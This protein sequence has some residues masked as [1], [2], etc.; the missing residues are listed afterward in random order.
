MTIVYLIQSSDLI[1]PNVLNIIPSQNQKIED[2]IAECQENWSSKDFYTKIQGIGWN[3]N[4]DDTSNK[5]LSSFALN[6]VLKIMVY[7]IKEIERCL[8]LLEK[9]D[10]KSINGW[11]E[12]QDF[13][14]KNKITFCTWGVKSHGKIHGQNEYAQYKKIE[15]EY[16]D[17]ESIM[18]SLSESTHFLELSSNI[19]RYID[20]LISRFVI[21]CKTPALQII[22][23]FNQSFE[24]E[25]NTKGTKFSE[26]ETKCI[27][28]LKQKITSI[29]SNLKLMEIR[30][31]Q[32]ETNPSIVT[33]IFYF[34]KN[35]LKKEAQSEDNIN[36]KTFIEKTLFKKKENFPQKFDKDC[37]FLKSEQNDMIENL[38]Y[39]L[40]FFQEMNTIHQV[41]TIINIIPNLNNK[42][43]ANNLFNSLAAFMKFFINIK[44]RDQM[45]ENY[46][47]FNSLGA[48]WINSICFFY[49]NLR[50]NTK[51][52][53]RFFY[54]QEECIEN[55]KCKKQ[56]SILHFLDRILEIFDVNDFNII[57]ESHASQDAFFD[58]IQEIEK[59][60]TYLINKTESSVS[61]FIKDTKKSA[62]ILNEECER[63]LKN[64]IKET[65]SNCI[66][67]LFNCDLS[68]F[69]FLFFYSLINKNISEKK[70]REKILEEEMTIWMLFAFTLYLKATIK[71]QTEIISLIENLVSSC[72]SDKKIVGFTSNLKSYQKELTSQMGFKRQEIHWIND[73]DNYFYDSNR[74][75]LSDY[76]TRNNSLQTTFA[77]VNAYVSWVLEDSQM[78][79]KDIESNFFGV[80][81][82]EI[83][84]D[85]KNI[86]WNSKFEQKDRVPLYSYNQ[87]EKQ[88]FSHISLTQ[89]EEIENLLKK[90]IKSHF[91]IKKLLFDKDIH[92][93][94]TI[95]KIIT[96][97]THSL[98]NHFFTDNKSLK[99]EFES[100][101]EDIKQETKRKEN[102]NLY[103]LAKP[104]KEVFQIY[105]TNSTIL[106]PALK[107]NLNFGFESGD[108]TLPWF[109]VSPLIVGIEN[110]INILLNTTVEN[111]YWE[112]DYIYSFANRIY[113]SNKVGKRIASVTQNGYSSQPVEGH[114]FFFLQQIQKFLKESQSNK[115]Y[116]AV[117]RIIAKINNQWNIDIISEDIDIQIK[118]NKNK[119]IIDL[120]KQIK[121]IFGKQL[122]L[123]EEF[124][125]RQTDLI[126]E[127]KNW[128][129]NFSK[130]G[131][132]KAEVLK[133]IDEITKYSKE[134]TRYF[135]II[136]HRLG[137]KED[138]KNPI[139]PFYKE[140]DKQYI[141]NVS[142]SK[143]SDKQDNID[144]ILQVAKMSTQIFVEVLWMR[145][146]LYLLSQCYENYKQTEK[147]SNSDRII[148]LDLKVIKKIISIPHMLVEIPR[149]EINLIGKI[150]ENIELSSQM[151]L[152]GYKEEINTKVEILKGIVAI[153]DTIKNLQGVRK[154]VS[155]NNLQF[156]AEYSTDE[157]RKINISKIL[158]ESYCEHLDINL[159]NKEFK[160]IEEKDL[161]ELRKQIKEINQTL[162]I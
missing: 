17:P 144:K 18:S 64:F 97:K 58:E 37:F 30:S 24:E 109:I 5:F 159:E 60:L 65:Y 22:N 75:F 28:Y 36:W 98:I 153:E 32:S 76:L 110:R 150:T 113:S 161:N 54:K 126:K 116:D 122:E 44:S 145:N 154:E 83:I 119:T 96:I 23:K 134:V 94:E 129:N 104:F 2:T 11:Y 19:V 72:I 35:Y 67:K 106:F 143:K 47:S 10:T 15:S 52:Y 31:K 59:L 137:L 103:T 151:K 73:F 16:G 160:H 68:T 108:Y 38:E 26:N 66:N 8:V 25:F 48:I 61:K 21:L 101:I 93:T 157:E 29:I 135:A 155:E 148:P 79:K 158:E 128:K 13:L 99:S 69:L 33:K 84:V 149:S 20:S 142:F 100:I 147:T 107:E 85:R 90:S 105:A 80:S 95:D 27:E 45:K 53:S 56:K 91:E 120:V 55:H 86:N 43:A 12:I 102:K 49:Y 57:R 136:L 125:K 46:R 81:Y 115:Y 7:I 1:Q 117:I 40:E 141:H 14:I 112:L 88:C 63:I 87:K 152:K 71:V 42:F 77:T 9:N 62:T 39:C 89:Y 162:L 92:E 132:E 127:S 4:I 70:T 50:E 139:M 74:V 140:N 34:F 118:N 131:I 138:Y 121:Q 78:Y 156:A 130:F 146:M 41:R 3:F 82:D 124:H 111:V 123:I 6:R 114:F 51:Y 133:K